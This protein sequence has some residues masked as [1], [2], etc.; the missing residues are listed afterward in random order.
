MKNLILCIIAF[1][2]FSGSALF[3][4]DLT[5]SWQ[6]SLQVQGNRLRAVVKISKD[7]GGLKAVVYSIDQ[8][9]QG[10]PAGA[11]SLESST[12]KIAIP[13]LAGAYEGKLTPDGNTMIGTF[14]QG[15]Q[16]IPLNLTRATKETAWAIPEPPAPPKPMAA[17]A[18]PVFEKAAIKPSRP[19]QPGL[20][21]GVQGRQ[22]TTLN[23]TLSILMAFAYGI[24]A[25]Q[26][27]EAPAWVSS[28]KFDLNAEPA[29][30]GQPNNVQW[31]AMVRKL[32]ADR[33]KLSFHR[34]KRE[35][36]IY[37]LSGGKSKLTPSAGDPN[38]LPGIGFA[39]LGRLVAQNATMADFAGVMQ[40]TAM[41]R[42]VVDQTEIAGRYDFTL[43][44][45]PDE[46]QFA[47][48]R[49]P[50]A[51]PLPATTPTNE[52][53]DLF[54]AIQQQLGLEL[55]STKAPV[56]VLVIDRVEK[57]AEN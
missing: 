2:L 55:K 34:D 19:D 38:G 20:G 6:G 46:S 45:T 15:P 23:T 4:Q 41:D 40:S 44:W 5:G 52:A 7:S 8:S 57:P 56:D 50:G 28:D 26:I 43:N 47:I 42:P 12:V 13:G 29:G 51:P 31:Q 25:Q 21:L 54:S 9:S 14:T 35:L 48:L 32:L 16:T 27:V 17:D 49:G 18:N 30:E 39:G 10:I 33:F 1:G 24:Q 3:G 53:P 11:I 36:S 22:F 37:A